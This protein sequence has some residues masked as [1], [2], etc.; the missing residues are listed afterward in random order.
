MVS[1]VSAPPPIRN[2]LPPASAEVLE[3]L[4]RLLSSPVLRESHQLQ[5]FLEFIVLE[6]LEGRSGTLKEYVLGCS[7]FGRKPDYDPRLDGIVRVQATALRKRLERYYLDEGAL[8][9]VII[10]LPRGGYA[11]R[12]R[13]AALPP[14]PAAVSVPLPLIALAPRASAP[15]WRGFVFSFL[16]GLL[17]AAA[18]WFVLSKPAVAPPP[19]PFAASHAKPSDFPELW[20]P[21]FEAGARNVVA[22]GVQS[23]QYTGVGEVE[24]THLMSN[25]FASQAVPVQVT[26]AQTLGPID[27]GERN[28]VVVSSLRFQTLLRDM[29]LPAAFEFLPRVPETIRNLK[30]Q[31]GESAE[32]VFRSAAGV[33]TSYALVSV[34]QGVAPSRRIVHIG[35]VHTWATQAA[36]EFLLQPDDLKKIALEFEKD[37][38]TGT[39]GPTSPFFQILLRVEGR[40]NQPHRVEYVTHHYTY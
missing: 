19:A 24:G 22:Y 28:L 33:S 15:S 13:Y 12:F 8:D 4:K 26:N 5:A 2:T 6:T 29:R 11:P 38:R 14:A 10:E 34:W 27:L 40:G 17:V 23:S 35:G 25:F 39:R 36:T 37:R 30:P 32:Y 21:F 3:Q 7:V 18:V 20:A 9:P 16:S 1:A 31:A